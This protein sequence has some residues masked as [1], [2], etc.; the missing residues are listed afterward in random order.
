MILELNTPYTVWT[1][2]IKLWQT[3]LLLLEYFK[4]YDG[5]KEEFCQGYTKNLQCESQM[6]LCIKRI[7]L[8]R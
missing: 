7:H 5:M 2:I 8:A 6:Y 1:N 4:N 3:T